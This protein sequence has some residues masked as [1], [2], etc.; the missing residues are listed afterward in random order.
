MIIVGI[1]YPDDYD[2]MK[3]RE[4]IMEGILQHIGLLQYEDVTK[5]VFRSYIINSPTVW[6][7]SNGKTGFEWEELL[8]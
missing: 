2:A 1:G 3:I 5:D 6:A 4:E 8:I 7:I